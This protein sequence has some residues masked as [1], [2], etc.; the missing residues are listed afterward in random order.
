MAPDGKKDASMGINAFLSTGIVVLALIFSA[1][2]FYYMNMAREISVA[3]TKIYG[4]YLPLT[5]ALDK[6]DEQKEHLWRLLGET[7]L[8]ASGAQ[9]SQDMQKSFARLRQTPPPG[10]TAQR[11]R[12]EDAVSSLERIAVLL[13]QAHDLEMEISS[14]VLESQKPPLPGGQSAAERTAYVAGRLASVRQALNSA[15]ADFTTALAGFGTRNPLADE[16]HGQLRRTA[17]LA[18]DF[19]NKLLL[20]F[21][22][23][24][25]GMMMLYG[26]LRL[27]VA[28]PLRGIMAYLDQLGT[29]VKKLLLPSSRIVEIRNIASAL[30]NLST[31]LSKATLQSKILVSEHDRFQ[32]MSLVDGLTGVRNRRSFDDSLRGLWRSARESQTPLALIML[33][34]D[35]FKIYND[36]YGHQAG[37]ECLKHVAAAMTRAA[38]STDI[39]AR[40]GGEEF[41]LLLP[42]ADAHTARAVAHRVHHEIEREQL[43]HPSSPVNGFV[44]V[45]LGVASLMPGKDMGNDGKLLVRNADAALYDAKSA[46]RNRTHVYGEEMACTPAAVPA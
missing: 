31:Y 26:I 7:V 23:L 30:D 38:R 10:T 14:P 33:D 21:L 43:P 41:A 35:K 39:C 8:A 16:M 13:A 45:S 11:Q 24:G 12:W 15:L 5:E 42:G 20:G 36:S 27:Q 29:G 34:V 17:T 37:D 28:R 1:S 32:K 25:A 44:T 6:V 2:F 18:H 3:S 4:A 22:F 40:Y 46:G 19:E 9:S